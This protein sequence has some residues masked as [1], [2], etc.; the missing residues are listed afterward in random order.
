MFKSSN[1][2][3]SHSHNRIKASGAV[4]GAF[5]PLNELQMKRSMRE[6]VFISFKNTYN[7]QRDLFE[8]RKILDRKL[9]FFVEKKC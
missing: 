8:V 9:I 2:Q 3:Q 6:T 1:M 5:A 4:K 7:V